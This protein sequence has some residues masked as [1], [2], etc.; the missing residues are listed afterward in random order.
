MVLSGTMVIKYAYSILKN[1]S[2]GQ[3]YCQGH[4][5]CVSQCL[6]VVLNDSNVA[7][8]IKPLTAMWLCL[9]Q[10]NFQT[11]REQLSCI[12]VKQLHKHFQPHNI[13]ISVLQSFKL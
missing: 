4:T 3:K 10:W 5:F 13:I 6:I 1:Y 2:Q 11:Q 7:M 9:S 12:G 8:Y